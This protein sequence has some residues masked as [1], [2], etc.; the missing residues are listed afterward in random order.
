[1][2]CLAEGDPAGALAAVTDV[3]DG[4]A[5]VLGSTVMAACLLAGLG[6]PAR[7]SQAVT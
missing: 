7:T 1:V 5:P 6:W 3:L 4:S 2:I